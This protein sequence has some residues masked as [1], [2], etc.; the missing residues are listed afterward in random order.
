MVCSLWCTESTRTGRGGREASG[1]VELFNLIVT[2][3]HDSIKIFLPG[4]EQREK[5]KKKRGKWVTPWSVCG[6][7]TQHRCVTPGVLARL[8]S[9]QKLDKVDKHSVPGGYCPK[10]VGVACAG[11]QNRVI[12]FRLIE[13]SRWIISINCNEPIKPGSRCVFLIRC[14]LCNKL[15]KCS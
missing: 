8:L 10:C 7:P 12:P 15:C 6:N 4:F 11:G 3:G 5:L 14:L 9:I 2:V 1:G 13:T